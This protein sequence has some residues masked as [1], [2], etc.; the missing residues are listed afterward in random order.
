MK[1]RT[2][3]PIPELADKVLTTEE[4]RA[5][6]EG[7]EPEEK[8]QEKQEGEQEFD[9]DLFL[10]LDNIVCV[11]EKN[12][13]FERYDK[14]YVSKGLH[15]LDKRTL[16]QNIKSMEGNGLFM[17]SF[18]LMCNILNKLYYRSTYR[19][20]KDAKAILKQYFS[21]M[22]KDWTTT[23]YNTII[24]W[25]TAEIIHYPTDADFLVHSENEQINLG[26]PR[27]KNS[28]VMCP[29]DI[30][31]GNVSDILSDD[32]ITTKFLMNL[33]GFSEADLS[34]LNNTVE[35]TLYFQMPTDDALNPITG[36]TLRKKRDLFIIDTIVDL[37]EEHHSRAVG[38]PKK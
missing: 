21:P 19:N 26:R 24:H 5:E 1:D 32:E 34:Y 36:V 38:V 29:E 10:E 2:I 27:Y 18:T 9:P 16:Y 22:A 35:G 3:K 17:P 15:F 33:T 4:A 11:D 14:L 37:N 30:K 6:F 31:G 23:Q 7:H 28:N 12:L 20:D 25:P 13:G 8:P